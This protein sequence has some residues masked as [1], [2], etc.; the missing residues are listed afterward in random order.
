MKRKTTTTSRE[1]YDDEKIANEMNVVDSDEEEKD[2]KNELREMAKRRFLLRKKN[3]SYSPT[4]DQY[5]EVFHYMTSC[6][7]TFS[8]FKNY[9]EWVTGSK[10][11][12]T[13][14]EDLALC[15]EN[16]KNRRELSEKGMACNKK[17]E[18]FV[19]VFLKKEAKKKEEDEK[20]EEEEQQEETETD[21]EKEVEEEEENGSKKQKKNSMVDDSAAEQP[22]NNLAS[23]RAAAS[24]RKK[25]V[26]DRFLAILK[27]CKIDQKDMKDEDTI[28]MLRF[29]RTFSTFEEAVKSKYLV[30][31]N[32]AQAAFMRLEKLTDHE[33]TADK[34]GH[35]IA[36]NFLDDLMEL[37]WNENP[38][39]DP[40]T[41]GE[42]FLLT[43][44]PALVPENVQKEVF[45]TEQ[46]GI[47]F[48]WDHDECLWMK[49][50][51]KK[52]KNAMLLKF[53]KYLLDF[54]KLTFKNNKSKAAWTWNVNSSTMIRTLHDHLLSNIKEDNVMAQLQ[55]FNVKAWHIPLRDDRVFDAS[56]LTIRKRTKEDYFSKRFKFYF[57]SDLEK[58]KKEFAG[59]TENNL[60]EKLEKMFPVP[61]DAMTKAFPNDHSKMDF[62]FFMAACFS[63]VPNEKLTMIPGTT[64]AGKSTLFN[65]LQGLFGDDDSTGFMHKIASDN[66][67]TTTQ[68]STPGAASPHLIGLA[69]KYLCFTDES[70][71]RTIDVET[72]KKLVNKK[73]RLPARDLY[74]S[75]V[76]MNLVCNYI[77]FYNPSNMP[78]YDSIDDAVRRRLVFI[79]TNV[80]IFQE[81]DIAKNKP[82]GFR[83][84]T[85]QDKEIRGIKW[86]LRTDKMLA[87]QK[88]LETQDG[89]NEL[90]SFFC[91][92]C[93]LYYTLTEGGDRKWAGS[94][95]LQ[96]NTEAAHD[97]Q[98]WLKRFIDLFYTVIPIVDEIDEEDFKLTQEEKQTL[99][100]RL[101]NL[102]RHSSLLQDVYKMY[103][104]YQQGK[105][106][107]VSNMEV[108]KDKLS[109]KGL[110]WVDENGIDR[111][112]L[113]L[114]E[115]ADELI[116]DATTDYLVSS[117]K[118]GRGDFC[119]LCAKPLDRYNPTRLKCHSCRRVYP[120]EV[121]E[122]KKVP[123]IPNPPSSSPV[124]QIWVSG[125][126]IKYTQQEKKVQVPTVPILPYLPTAPIVPIHPVA[127]ILPMVTEEENIDILAAEEEEIKKEQE[128][129][130][131]S[132]DY[133]IELSQEHFPSLTQTESLAA[134]HS[135]AEALRKKE[136]KERKKKQEEEK[137][138]EA[139]LSKKMHFLDPLPKKGPSG[140]FICKEPGCKKD[141][142]RV[143]T[144]KLQCP[145]HGF[146]CIDQDVSKDLVR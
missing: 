146:Y 74:K 94:L 43:V 140:N 28:F 113:I 34:Q 111:V 40:P 73:T 21:E 127:S 119:L 130:P 75:V 5:P 49:A 36:T 23:K 142:V 37:V 68:K 137:K 121:Q 58:I 92:I 81:T 52:M 4:K 13:S 102:K 19:D 55:K 51:E 89:L 145:E 106:G 117:K 124:G 38:L 85:W 14:K 109:L 2:I 141:Y 18:D 22:K 70:Q 104:I 57:T 46:K 80:R 7:K 131:P 128:E 77:W 134:L 144:R 48:V 99:P 66:W 125:M 59:V 3:P 90:G 120:V 93:H 29:F 1:H 8:T 64:G 132:P 86:I 97:R 105:N 44:F 129:R 139:E 143:A 69:N 135:K 60:L 138:K 6:F 54:K 56:T 33:M 50:E 26:R 79:N 45:Y 136:A 62:L 15:K 65:V 118:I 31:G 115:N 11:S 88:W 24:R 108:F 101:E 17:G 42:K 71:N 53:S 10:M 72:L 95:T 126:D 84:A 20:Q 25:K 114:K 107:V 110:N 87:D 61:Y 82:P 16:W 35:S 9:V 32:D 83:K 112:Y 96:K 30:E 41:Q 39:Y 76:M 122:E 27:V 98:D 47:G 12:K 91:V 133:L 78:K 116:R 123:L 103:K 63:G 100:E 67:F